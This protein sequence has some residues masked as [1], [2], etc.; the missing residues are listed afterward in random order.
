MLILAAHAKKIGQKTWRDA[1][2][3]HLKKLQLIFGNGRKSGENQYFCVVRQ[4]G[5][6]TD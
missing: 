5:K 1:S 3:L 4:T 2:K 6:S